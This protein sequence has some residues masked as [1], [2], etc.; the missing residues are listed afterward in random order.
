M[1]GRLY[2]LGWV[3]AL[4]FCI[5]VG[6]T[7]LRS[8]RSPAE[9]ICDQAKTQGAVCMIMDAKLEFLDDGQVFLTYEQ[10]KGKSVTAKLK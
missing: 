8:E 1:K 5:V 9:Q 6:I 10:A 2:H 7:Q 3:V 4:L